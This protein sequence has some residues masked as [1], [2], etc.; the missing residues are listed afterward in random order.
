MN[1]NAWAC[2]GTDNLWAGIATAL[3][4]TAEA[5]FGRV[6]T[7]LTRMLEIVTVRNQTSP[8]DNGTQFFANLG[9]DD[10]LVET[11][12][13]DLGVV[14]D[15]VRYK[16]WKSDCSSGAIYASWWVV[17]YKTSLQASKSYQY[18]SCHNIP[19][20]FRDPF[21]SSEPKEERA[22][23]SER[24]SLINSTQDES[25][26]PGGGAKIFTMGLLLRS[27]SKTSCNVPIVSWMIFLLF[28]VFLP[29]PLTI[30]AN[31]VSLV[32][33]LVALVA[34]L[35]YTMPFRLYKNSFGGH[36]CEV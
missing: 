28:L 5:E 16:D 9:E 25:E 27:Y 24:T 13:K 33:M 30:Y 6:T 31:V 11:I 20:S 35:W 23:S 19:V 14:T 34:Y 18:L 36:I 7:R 3:V 32:Y 22:E 2:T 15:C 8:C 1:F 12:S 26:K 29:I 17:S 10:A 4:A 21:K